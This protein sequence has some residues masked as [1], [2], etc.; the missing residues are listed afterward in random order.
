[1]TTKEAVEQ[2]VRAMN[3]DPQYRET[4]QAN[5]AMSF[6]DEWLRDDGVTT[7]KSMHELANRAAHNFL[8]L[9]C[10]PITASEAIK[11]ME[12]HFDR[13]PIQLY[14]GGVDFETYKSIPDEST[15]TGFLY[16]KPKG[17]K[18]ERLFAEVIK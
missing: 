6:Y 16:S 11:R 9:L 18:E 15:L 2:L 7:R 5:I 4:W 1:M 17:R 3:E 8:T 12:S 13:K 14:I 10:R